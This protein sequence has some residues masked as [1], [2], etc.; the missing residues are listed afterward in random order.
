M[1]S[2]KELGNNVK[3]ARRYRSKKSGMEFTSKDLAIKIGETTKWVKRLE[4]GEF[5]PDWDA[6]NFIADVCG[7]E[8][9]SL[10]GEKFAD[11]IEYEDAIK[12][13]KIARTI[14]DEELRA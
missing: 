5:Y 10:I 7:V 6:I 1:Y 8:V 11:E 14:N 13:G 3:N 2:T 12:G 9:E 4:R